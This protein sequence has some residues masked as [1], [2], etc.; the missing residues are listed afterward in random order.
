MSPASVE[1]V[2]DDGVPVDDTTPTPDQPTA[3]VPPA[4]PANAPAGSILAGLEQ[5]I[6]EHVE[7]AFKVL[8][9][10]KVGR[11]KARYRVLGD[12]EQTRIERQVQNAAK[13]RKKTGQDENTIDRENDSC[14]LLLAT[15]CVE[16]L[17]VDDKGNTVPLHEMLARPD[18][19][20]DQAPQGPLRYDRATYELLMPSRAAKLREQL[21][22][23][24]TS[25]DVAMDLHR[26]GDGHSPLRSYGKLLNLWM[27][28]ASTEAL[29]E[30]AQGN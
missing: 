8:P 16:L 13:M 1:L 27:G 6:Q 20:G 5:E 19:M 15:A 17:I 21:G 2:G 3:T 22:R 28:G 23:D 12:D 11:F 25:V 9:V 7:E 18:Q 10:G 4:E 26:W 30:A 14:A 29:A 24:L